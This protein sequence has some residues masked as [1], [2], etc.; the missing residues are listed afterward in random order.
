MTSWAPALQRKEALREVEARLEREP[1]CVDLHFHRACLLAETGDTEEAKQ[2]YLDVLSRAPAHVGALNNLGT[3]LYTTGYRTAARS[4]YTEAIARHPDHPMAHVNLGN[5]FLEAGDLAPA[6]EHY[7]A[8]LALDSGF[9][10][11]HQGLGNLLAELGH[12]EAAARHQRLGL[13]DQRATELPY[14]GEAEPV[15][16]LLLV[17]GRRGD[18]P[19]RHLLDDKIFRTFVVLPNVYDP[20]A[21][22]PPH[23]VV[24]NAI[25]DA[26][27]C[28]LALDRAVTLVERTFAPVINP[29]AAVLGTGRAANARRLGEIPGVV[30]PVIANLSRAVLSSTDATEALAHRGL[31]FPL[32]L[33]APGCHNGRHFL[34]VENADGLKAALNDLPGDELIAIR[35]LGD[36]RGAD[37]KYRKYRVMMIGGWLYPLHLAISSHWKIHYVTA[38]MN[39]Q[40]RAEEAKFLRDMPGVLGPVAMAALADIQEVLGLDYAGIDFGLSASGEVL[41]FEAN[42]TMIVVPPGLERRWD[43][44]RAAVQRV[45]D[46]VRQ[47][48]AGKALDGNALAT[49]VH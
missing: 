16:L 8:E 15:Q 41:L 46:A 14:R 23:D 33:R 9:A 31:E 13:W 22:L 3:L 28:A 2:A 17:S 36:A 10:E 38:D 35:Y 30:A 40:H 19:I 18:V 39:E 42:A 11:A 21:P 45:E 25:G 26:D 12:E 7:A 34:R 24:F 43:Y 5:I 49:Q 6:R 29:P 37:G 4:A 1:E 20:D 47:M 48:L 27:S 44:R 32:L